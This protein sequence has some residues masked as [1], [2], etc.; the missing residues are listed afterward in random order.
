MDISINH[1]NELEAIIRIGLTPEDYSKRIEDV[2]KQY[3]KTAQVPGF[4]PGK[5]PTGVIRK[6]YGKSVLAEELNK[7][8]SESLGKYIYDNKLPVLGTPLPHQSEKEQVLVEGNSFEFNYE[9]GLAPQFKVEI[10]SG[11][12]PYYLVKIDAEMVE[13]DLNDL[14]RRYGKFSNPEVSEESS[15]LYGEFNELDAENL[16]KE[17]GNKTTT[18]LSI[19]MIRDVQHRT[20]FLGLKAKD[21][22]DFNPLEVL[23]NETEVAAMLKLQK[24]SPALHSPYRFTVMTVNKIEKADMNQELYDK[25]YGEGVVTTEEEF[26]SKIREGIASY[27]ERESDRKLKKDLRMTMVE[28]MN[29]PLPD[30][31]LKKMLK[32]NNKNESADFEHEYFHLADDLRWDLIQS[33]IAEANEIAVSEDEIR[34][35]AR[36]TIRQQF[37]QYGYFD[38]D[39]SKEKDIVERYLREDDRAEKLERAIRDQK[40]FD[41]L[42]KEVKL[43]MTEL[44]YQDFVQKLN[45]QTQHE[46]EHHHH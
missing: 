2:L 14:R 33:R 20:P 1:T 19:E 21:T 37:A 28:S 45:E 38:L 39:E 12:V 29:I 42:K 8:L 15:V 3:Q 6:M 17:G 16:I 13:N 31:F 41:Y 9:V 24:D 44:P 34:E 7:L 11:K 27:F 35:L 10:P 25:V 22:V 30:E 46:L 26:R 23:K 43:D 18:T 5:V 4:R 40:V 32:A 36:Q